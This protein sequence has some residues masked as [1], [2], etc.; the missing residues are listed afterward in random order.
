MKRFDT[1]A[2]YHTLYYVLLAVGSIP[3]FFL[4][5]NIFI[6]TLWIFTLQT[7]IGWAVYQPIKKYENNSSDP[8]SFTL[9]SHLTLMQGFK[10]I[11]SNIDRIIA[12]A[13]AGPTGV[14]IYTFAITPIQKATQ[15][16]PI[17]TVALPYLSHHEF[18]KKTKRAILKKTYFLFGLTIPLTIA[19]Y[20]LAPF[21][22]GL[23]F[24]KYPESLPLFQF[25]ILNIIFLPTMLLK[26]SLIAFNKTKILYGIEIGIPLLKIVLMIG[27]SLFFGIW[28]IV[29]G[30]VIATFFDA[31]ISW[32]FFARLPTSL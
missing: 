31:I 28:G 5:K 23:L 13:F 9:A 10:T 11:A 1:S 2:F 30:I 7:I 6:I 24:P 27:L 12:Y 29:I 15:L 17:G 8:E 25:L 16:V 21:V 3:I 32:L 18:T 19:A 22:Y 26:S 4:S 20:F 14:A